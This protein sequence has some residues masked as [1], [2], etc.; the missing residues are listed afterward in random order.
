MKLGEV[1][2]I[3]ISPDFEGSLRSVE[4]VEVEAGRGLVGDRFHRQAGEHPEK[5]VP[6]REVTLIEIEALEAL[7][8]ESG[9]EMSPL[10][11]RRN[12][13]TRGVALNHLVGREFRVGGVLLYGTGLC[14]PCRHLEKMTGKNVRAG[15][16]HRGGLCARI[17]SGGAIST[18]DS[19][20]TK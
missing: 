16:V 19:I 4:R 18:G 2:S 1:L 8:R 15:L 3:Q 20:E 5:H 7:A 12:L 17:I 10:E 9:I 6:D 11:S 14:E 13:A